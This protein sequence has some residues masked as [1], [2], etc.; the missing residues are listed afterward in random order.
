M[1]RRWVFRGGATVA[2]LGLTGFGAWLLS[3]PSAPAAVGAPAIDDRETTA[4][5]D[6][7]KPPKRRR[8]VIAVV[9]IN[10]ATETTD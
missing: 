9:G 8:P 5:L 10:D 2:V 4:V 6:A 3:L 7:L 1:T